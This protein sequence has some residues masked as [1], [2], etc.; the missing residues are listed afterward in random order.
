MGWA[1]FNP[2]TLMRIES[3]DGM[4][5]AKIWP[6]LVLFTAT[7]LSFFGRHLSK[8]VDPFDDGF[9]TVLMVD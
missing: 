3:E 6:M 8:L 2:P 4:R 1:S 7:C 9:G 5:I